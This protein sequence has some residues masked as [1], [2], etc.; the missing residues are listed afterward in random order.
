MARRFQG[1]PRVS[2]RHQMKTASI[3]GRLAPPT[4]MLAAEIWLACTACVVISTPAAAQFW[5]YPFWGQRQAPQQR[6]YRPWGGWQQGPEQQQ[7]WSQPPVDAS[8]APPPR[9]P[10]SAPAKTVA[11]LGD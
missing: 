1:R 4:L 7:R 9:K 11:V 8:K 6:Q 3:P 2:R 10:E 5:D